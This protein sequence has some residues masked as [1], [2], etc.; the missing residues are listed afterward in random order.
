MS[1]E[2]KSMRVT[3]FI[4]HSIVYVAVIFLLLLVNNLTWSGYQW[5]LWP[6]IGWGIGVTAHFLAVFI[7]VFS[8]RFGGRESAAGG[9]PAHEE[10]MVGGLSPTEILG[11]TLGSIAALV[12][13]VGFIVGVQMRPANGPWA[14]W[15]APWSGSFRPGAPR[16]EEGGS[17]TGI[18]LREEKD[19]TV[20]GT[21]N[22]VEIQTVAGEI[23]VK[24]GST[25]GVQIHSVKTAPTVSAMQAIEVG[26]EQ[27]GGRLLINEKR[28]S[29]LFNRS[30][31]ISYTVTIPDGPKSITAHSVSG[32]ITVDVKSVMEQDLQTISGGIYTSRSGDLHANSTS[33][34]IRFSFEGDIL[35]ARTVS[36][37]IQGVISSIGE[38][39]TANLG[40]ISGS[41][42]LQ[43]FPALDASL[44]LHSVSGH[45]SCDFPLAVSVQKNNSL[46]GKIGSGAV[47]ISVN[48]ISG[49]INLHTR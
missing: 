5:W 32:S 18:P 21:F 16:V 14:G 28:T 37:S 49:S 11:T 31:S 29:T 48:T 44:T 2:K 30:G 3:G 33:G 36:G 9:E 20:H 15:S 26:I 13:I 34:E 17:Q 8:A 27:Q 25:G 22:S 43:A 38:N 40:T 7:P 12:V 45:V 1:D 35:E 39:G 23:V 41:V 24:G 47:P 46:E 10:R 19:Q 4:R 42:D 6:A